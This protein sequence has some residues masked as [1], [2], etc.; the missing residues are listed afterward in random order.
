VIIPRVGSILT[1]WNLLIVEALIAQGAKSPASAASL[2]LAADK[3]RSTLHL[4]RAEVPSVP[5][6]MVREIEE[7]EPILEMMGEQDLI[8]KLPHG[9]HGRNVVGTKGRADALRQCESWFKEGHAVLVQPWIELAQARD[10]RVLIVSG[11]AVAACWRVARPGEFRSN[12][13]Q[14]GRAIRAE[15]DDE[16]RHLSESAA[17]AIGLNCGG[18]DLLEAPQYAGQGGRFAVLEVN[19]CPGLESVESTSGM[20]AARAIIEAAIRG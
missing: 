17:E 9:T 3:A 20:D 18:V 12:L 13:H 2:A 11:E 14:G 16:I 8:L 1:N 6:W 19:G 4:S 10:M 15:V 5:T 7:V